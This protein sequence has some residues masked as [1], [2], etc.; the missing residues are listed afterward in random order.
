MC[1][2]CA[3]SQLR[4][5]R[6]VERAMKKRLEEIDRDIA[7]H[8]TALSDNELDDLQ[9]ERESCFLLI[10]QAWEFLGIELGLWSDQR[11]RAP[12]S[13]EQISYARR[14]LGRGRQSVARSS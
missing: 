9:V 13:D 10:A 11:A 2:R 3:V 6:H 8:R 1:L 12:W 7:G 5:P 4:D 14:L